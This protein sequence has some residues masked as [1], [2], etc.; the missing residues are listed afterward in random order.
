MWTMGLGAF[1]ADSFKCWGLI[2]L[3]QRG[4]RLWLKAVRSIARGCSGVP[5][6]PPEAP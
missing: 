3:G 5:R 6:Q 1:T 2:T 4:F